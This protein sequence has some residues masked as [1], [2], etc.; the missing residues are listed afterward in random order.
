MD[1]I[2]FL[3]RLMYFIQAIPHNLIPVNIY[4]TNILL[5]LVLYMKSTFSKLIVSIELITL[6]GLAALTWYQ[7]HNSSS[8]LSLLDHSAARQ[9]AASR[10]TESSDSGRADFIKWVDFNVTSEAMNDAY[11]YDLKSHDTDTPIDWVSLLAVMGVKYGGDFKN[12]KSSDMSEVADKILNKESTL[13]EITK[14]M[15]YFDYYN[16]AYQAVLG[17]FV[18][19][20]TILPNSSAQTNPDITTKEN[21]GAAKTAYGL[22]AFSPIAKGFPYTDY[23]DFGTSRSFGFRRQ[24]LG[25]DMMGQIGTPIIAVESGY[26][27]CLGWNRYGGWR[28]GIRS[29]DQKRY[30]YYAHLRQNFPYNKSLKEGSVVTAGDVIGYMGHTGYSDKENVN[31]IDIIHLHFGMQLIFDES[32][33]DGN[34]E[35]WISCYELTRFLSQNRCEAVKDEATK[36]WH[37][38][39]DLIDP[40]VENYKKISNKNKITKQE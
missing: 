5:I 13:E 12:Y 4:F 25:H 16:E 21:E 14:D 22:K 35:I 27:E 7:S 31:N 15:K 20:Y 34:G 19:E 32:Q 30:Y 11:Q 8:L 28:I 1:F 36:E 2:P 24:H 39:Q 9:P 40:A 26:V 23:D 10:N 38:I 17:G 6:M 29:F 3:F 18:G 37:R 33:K